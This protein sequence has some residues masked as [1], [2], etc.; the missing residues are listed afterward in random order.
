VTEMPEVPKLDKLIALLRM[1]ASDNDNEALL[2]MR[3]ATRHILAAGW[4][5]ERLLRS[6]V[7]VVADP[8]ANISTPPQ[9]ADINVNVRPHTPT[10]SSARGASGGGSARAPHPPPRGPAYHC[11][12]CG[13][14][15]GQAGDFCCGT[16]MRS[17]P[18]PPRPTITRKNQYGGH[19]HQC[20]SPVDTNQ[21]HIWKDPSG[22]WRM[23]C[24]PCTSAINSGTAQ[25]ASVAA[26][27]K[28][29]RY[30]QPDLGS[31]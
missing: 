23:F 8:F 4:D 28:Y 19:C 30:A 27:K 17:T 5:W 29:N 12:T 16:S 2:A 7:T 11:W 20:G 24:V 6:R 25:V 22:S 26:K 3:A 1:T 15:T 18:C 14:S 31:L 21:G 10:P 13:S 9:R